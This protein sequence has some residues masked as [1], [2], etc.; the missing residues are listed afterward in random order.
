[1]STSPPDQPAAGHGDPDRP[2]RP[3]DGLAAAGDPATPTPV[4]DGPSDDATAD[5]EAR[6]GSGSAKGCA[7]EEGRA[8]RDAPA[9]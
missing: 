4:H 7:P 1:M 5:I 3:Y 2:R 9:Y 6:Q 8:P